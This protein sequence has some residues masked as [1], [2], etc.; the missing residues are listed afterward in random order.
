MIHLTIPV[1][2]FLVLLH[3]LAGHP[4]NDQ[5]WPS[6]RG[7]QARGSTEGYATPVHWDLEKSENIRWK[8]PIPGLGHSCPRS[9]GEDRILRHHRGEGMTGSRI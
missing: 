5:N 6:F 8:T 7:F 4:D 1:Y 3:A 2:G 9:F